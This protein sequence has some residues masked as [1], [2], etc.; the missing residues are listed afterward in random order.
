[1]SLAGEVEED[2]TG[3]GD[4]CREEEGLAELQENDIKELERGAVGQKWSKM[5]YLALTPPSPFGNKFTAMSSQHTS[6]TSNR[7][8]N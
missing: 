2:A 7:C 6:I 4:T 3:D 1:M 5:E 8:G